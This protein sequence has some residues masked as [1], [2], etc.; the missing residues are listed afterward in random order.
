MAVLAG[1][2]HARRVSCG[3]LVASNDRAVYVPPG[4]NRE[5]RL[6]KLEAERRQAVRGETAALHC[7]RIAF[8]M[9]H[10][11]LIAFSMTSDGR[12]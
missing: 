8:A 10:C 1:E 3:H 12:P 9:S 6:Q 2:T 4:T 5:A 11:T 7:I